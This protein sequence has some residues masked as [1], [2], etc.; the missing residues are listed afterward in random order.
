[1][2][3]F[4]LRLG[5]PV[6]VL[7]LGTL[8]QVGGAHAHTATCRTDPTVTLSN[9][10]TMRLY[11]DIG[12]TPSDVTGIMYVLVVPIGVMMTSVS[13]SGPLPDS[14]QSIA[15]IPAGAPGS[16]DEYAYVET[17]AANV[18]VDAFMSTS[19]SG[20]V[21]VNGHSR[22]LLHAHLQVV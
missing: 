4:R 16:Y 3:W 14:A 12:D 11:E 1:M 7:L 10:V 15:L 17:G 9:G 13:Y 8:G 5:I 19:D 18:P 6:V 2:K 21:H 20:S 22:E